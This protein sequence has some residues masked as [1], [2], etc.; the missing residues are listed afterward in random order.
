MWTAKGF[1]GEGCEHLIDSLKGQ[2]AIVAGNARGVFEEVN[3]AESRMG[4]CLVF[5]VN[6]VAVLLPRVDH[7]VSLHTPK[8]EHWRYLRLD[9]T[10]KGYG[11]KDF[12]THD[13]GLY[14]KTEFHQWKHLTPV[15]ALSGYFAAQIAYL[16]GCSPIV[17][18]G[19]PG[20][21]TPCFWSNE[22][23]SGY[24][25]VQSSFMAE[26]SRNPEFRGALRSQSGWT[27]EFLGS[28]A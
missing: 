25:K 7:M 8:L 12:Q 2:P 22:R 26:I 28:Y 21:D 15:L 17:L 10:S 14:G 9:P 5:G 3:A 16:M 27:R 11:N 13:A 1:S 24:E 19:C 4:R 6:D 23:S 18:C 20:D